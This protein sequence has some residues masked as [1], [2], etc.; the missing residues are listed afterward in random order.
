MIVG[1]NV[2]FSRAQ[3]FVG[4]KALRQLGKMHLM[5]SMKWLWLNAPGSERPCKLDKAFYGLSFRDEIASVSA[6]LLS[7]WFRMEWQKQWLG[8]KFALRPNTLRHGKFIARRNNR[9]GGQSV[10]IS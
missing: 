5:E 2:E 9:G 10:H 3:A 7:P 1:E 6:A 4:C 8:G